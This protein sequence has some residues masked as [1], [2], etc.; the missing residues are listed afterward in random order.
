[1]IID[2]QLDESKEELL[3]ETF[4]EV[5]EETGQWTQE[6]AMYV[7]VPEI[8]HD[9]QKC[10]FYNPA[11]SCELVEG[12][13]SP[14]G[15]CRFWVQSCSEDEVES[16]SLSQSIADLDADE[17][18][19]YTLYLM[20]DEELANY[21][22]DTLLENLANDLS[23]EV[24][25]LSASKSVSLR[26]EHKSEK[27][28]L[29]EAGRRYLNKKE[30]SNLKPGVKGAAKT[31][32]QWRRKGSFLRRFYSK[33]SIPP[34]KKPNGKPTRFA[35]AA[36]LRKDVP[37]L[38]ADGTYKTIGE[39]VDNKL[40]VDVVCINPDTL[41]VTTSPVTGWYKHK[42]S[43]EEFISLGNK[44]T[45]EVADN[46]T[47]FITLTKDHKVF[48]SEGWVSAE[49][50]VGRKRAFIDKA[51]TDKAAIEFIY[52]AL[53]GD[54]CIPYKPRASMYMFFGHSLAQEDYLKEKARLLGRVNKV[55]YSEAVYEHDGKLKRRPVCKVLT[56]S[57]ITFSEMRREWYREGLKRLPNNIEEVLSPLSLAI[58]IA[59][60][61]CL[62]KGTKNNIDFYHYR[63]HTEGFKKEDTERLLSILQTKFGLTGN[64]RKKENCEGYIINIGTKESVSKLSSLIAPY[65]INSMRYK[66][67][68]EHREVP[69]LLKDV[70]FKTEYKTV[71][72]D[73]ITLNDPATTLPVKDYLWKYDI[74]VD[75]YH[76]FV[77]GGTVVHN[78]AWGEPVPTN[79][80]AVRRLAAKG[81]AL[82]KKYAAWKERNKKSKQ[83]LSQSELLNLPLLLSNGMV[84]IPIAKKGNFFH[85]QHG[86]VSF[87]DEDFAQIKKESSKEVL[88][89]TPYITYGHP[90]NLPYNTIDGELKKGDLKGWE[91]EDNVLFGLFEAKEDVFNLV[92][93]GEYEYSSGEFL[94]NYK[95][96]FTGVNKGTVLMRVALTNSPFIPFGDTKVEALSQQSNTDD[97]C[98]PKSI[99]F[100]I[101]LST[102]IQENINPPIS[103]EDSP[104]LNMTLEKTPEQLAQEVVSKLI[105]E[106]ESEVDPTVIETTKESHVVNKTIIEEPRKEEVKVAASPTA[107]SVDINALFEK[108]AAQAAEST[109]TAVNAVTSKYEA[110]VSGLNT[111]IE[112]LKAQLTNQ[113]QVTQ[114]FSTSLSNQAKLQEQKELLGYGVSPVLI[115][116]FSQL[117]SALET[118]QTV[119]K[120]STKAADGQVSEVETP[121][122]NALK[123]LLI[124]AVYSEP[125][126]LQQF[127]QSANK[128]PPTG[129][130]AA[131]NGLAEENK[132]KAAKRSL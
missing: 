46:Y 101:K 71:F 70:E 57:S 74:T 100:V 88:G 64:I 131:I 122:V 84:K 20:Q 125:V 49:D 73:D 18:F 104:E 68:P 130:M 92:K 14:E 96:K 15:H 33:D 103:E 35:L 127:G 112:A 12:N 95:D 10:C 79:M 37:I 7:V 5:I 22:F 66:V 42:S 38:L 34:L 97:S 120:L 11:G 26:K 128:I 30:N 109:K 63:I 29:T 93:N 82:L 50:C 119:V 21:K 4:E 106:S 48:T 87:T 43:Y 8:D 41:E 90:T 107:S 117:Q 6:E 85:E 58:W 129:L 44:K 132:A 116:K 69:Y 51:Y 56:P 67:L 115:Q 113:E 65:L 99:P 81:E 9:C 28:G 80:A 25:E 118:K 110:V 27:G 36:C 114:A 47:K 55:S 108:F 39:I 32:E 72:L 40:Q 13:I 60:D 3:E 75:T 91:E 78:S 105:P 24:Q 89:F 102:D 126:N 123:E 121:V 45:P 77:A 2:S 54:S 59:D 83:K 52:G 76:N 1:M 94:R 16:Y 19:F 86:I 61:G 62:H 124:D 53:L 111:Q 23:D 31:P 17:D 98:L